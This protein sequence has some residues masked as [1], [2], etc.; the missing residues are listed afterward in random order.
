MNEVIPTRSIVKP[1]PFYHAL[2]GVLPFLGYGLVS[3]VFHYGDFWRREPAWLHYFLVFD[4]LLLL[5]LFAGTLA[6]FPHWAYSYLAWALIVA[7][8][9]SDIR[10]Y[11]KVTLD[12]RMWLL[13]L[14][15]L[16][17]ALLL[18]R[19][20]QPLRALFTGLWDDWTLLSFGVYSFFSFGFLLYDENHNPNLWAFMI[21]STLAACAAAWFYFRLAAPMWRAL[22]LVVGLLTLFA[23][24]KVNNATWDFR[25]YYNLPEGDS[26]F[27]PLGLM[28][29]VLLLGLLLLPGLLSRKRKRSS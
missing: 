7:W 10:I 28:M 18:R 16:A 3:L 9:L 27:N 4:G 14:A 20:L 24:D 21:I 12:S 17:L 8:W 19:S 15:A 1:V 22:V 26:S 5:G 13:P 6:G 23:I 25:A 29:L 2:L 11:G